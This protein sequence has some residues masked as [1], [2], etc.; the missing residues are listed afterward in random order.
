MSFPKKANGTNK[1]SLLLPFYSQKNSIFVPLKKYIMNY[2]QSL[3]API[4]ELISKIADQ[5]SQKCFV[6]G[7]FV[8]DLLL[9]RGIA[10]DIDIVT[11][12]SGIEL[13]EKVAAQ[14]P[15]NPK[16]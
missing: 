13:A 3:T 11:L 12:G 15:N 14:L 7:G 8:R 2:S 1:K 16:I 9:K 10:K 5:N 4:F 6:V